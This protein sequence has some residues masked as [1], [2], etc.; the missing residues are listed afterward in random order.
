MKYLCII[1]VFLYREDYRALFHPYPGLPEPLLLPEIEKNLDVQSLILLW[2]LNML[3]HVDVQALPT[4]MLLPI[5]I[6][7]TSFA[8][9][10]EC[11]GTQNR[12]IL[13]CLL[14]LV[15]SQVGALIWLWSM[16]A[17]ST[18]PNCHRIYSCSPKNSVDYTEVKITSIWTWQRV[19]SH[20]VRVTGYFLE[21]N[22]V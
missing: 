1:K 5:Q 19:V 11:I 22:S 20:F 16:I 9:I 7:L 4:A 2:Q 8:L 15:C 13:L 14:G 21:S 12:F 18:L 6:H 17:S 3:L 10:S